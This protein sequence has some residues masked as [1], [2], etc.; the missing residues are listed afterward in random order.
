MAA[1]LRGILAQRHKR[2]IVWEESCS[3]QPAS[4]ASLSLP[5]APAP[6]K[7][8]RAPSAWSSTSGRSESRERTPYDNPLNDVVCHN[9][10]N[11]VRYASLL[12]FERFESCSVLA[13]FPSMSCI[14][15]P[16]R[17]AKC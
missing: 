9:W 16:T 4:W 7:D 3:N 14:S 15:L 5:P 2:M 6:L 1:R 8:V 10:L 17:A 12:N 11:P 13:W